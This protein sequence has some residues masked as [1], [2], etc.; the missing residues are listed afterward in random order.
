VALHEL[1]QVVHTARL[2]YASQALRH[3]DLFATF[4]LTSG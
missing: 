1:I 3:A 4:G 2:R